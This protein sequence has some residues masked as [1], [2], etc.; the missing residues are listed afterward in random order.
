MHPC[1]KFCPSI[2]I[3]KVPRTSMSLKSWFG[4]LDDAWGSWLGFGI[5]ILIWIWSLSFGTPML[6]NLALYLDFQG[7]KN[8]HVL[9]FLIFRIVE[10]PDKGFWP[11]SWFIKGLYAQNVASLSWFSRCKEHLCPLNTYLGLSR[12]PELP[13]WGLASLSSDGYGHWTLI[14]PYSEF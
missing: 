7:A 3:L 4:A 10:V 6:Q 1:S 13:D 9:Y 8:M 12:M 14:H 11:L 2:L 5:L